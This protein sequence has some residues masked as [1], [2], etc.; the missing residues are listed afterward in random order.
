MQ[1]YRNVELDNDINAR[2][3][4]KSNKPIWLIGDPVSHPFLDV[5]C[6][7]I[8]LRMLVCVFVLIIIIQIYVVLRW[9]I[10]LS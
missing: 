1:Q 9:S 2:V 4:F 6:V 3:A 8:N 10:N 5:C 7:L